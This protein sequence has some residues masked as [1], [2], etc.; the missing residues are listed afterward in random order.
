MSGFFEGVGSLAWDAINGVAWLFTSEVPELMLSLSLLLGA[1]SVVVISLVLLERKYLG[2][3]Q[4]RMGPMRVGP[5][6]VL[7]PVADVVKLMG[8]ED[9][10]PSWVDRWVYYIAPLVLF[11]PSFVIWVTIPSSP[12]LV[13]RDLELGLLYVIAF[14][15]VSIVGLIMAGWGSANKYGVLGGLRSVAQLIS[16]E[17]PIIAVALTVALLAGSLNLVEIVEKQSPVPFAVLQPLGLFLFLMA[18]LAE[19]GRTPFDIYHAESEIMGGP[20]VEYSG[21]HWAIFYLA[22]YINTFLL[23]AL[24]VVLF[25]GGWSGPFLPPIL[26]FL[27]K[28]YAV[29]LLFFWFRGTFPRLRIDQLMS[30]AWKVLVPLSFF[31]LMLAAAARFYGWPDWALAVAGLAALVALGAL[32]Y[33]A[34]SGRSARPALRLVPAREVRRA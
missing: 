13:L 6:G 25:L 23:A 5:H 12:T 17:I 34:T 15:V 30:L 24:I 28:T 1:L 33:R 9:I 27:L 32:T 26:W 21:A 19:V 3:L 20:F 2:R 8:K 10:M 31:N 16:Y 18:G 7:Q 4:M 14:S 29:V 22:E 11:V